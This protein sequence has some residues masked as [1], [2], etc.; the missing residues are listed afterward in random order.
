MSRKPLQT[1]SLL[2]TP[3][4]V[5][6]Q[7][8]EALREADIDKLM[9]VWAEDEEVLCVHPGG[10]RLVGLAAVRASYEALF[11]HGPVPL[12]PENL[13][14]VVS[15]SCAVHSL[16]EKMLLR[17]P[18]GPRHG[19]VLA[20]NVYLKTSQGW[21]MVTHHGG[22]GMADEPLERIETPAVLH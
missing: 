21:R 7:F 19:W 4:D 6:A 11:K 12:E 14:R 18:E 1:L 17:T 20:T 16:L 3:D 22:P 13:H 8:Y 15:L 5:E 9:A 10:L 2:S